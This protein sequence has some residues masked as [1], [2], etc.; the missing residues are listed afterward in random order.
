MGNYTVDFY[1][2]YGTSDQFRHYRLRLKGETVY[3]FGNREPT[4]DEI[5]NA[6]GYH[7]GLRV[8]L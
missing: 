3:E 5:I 6:V 8:I 4:Q 1:F 7:Q 2:Q